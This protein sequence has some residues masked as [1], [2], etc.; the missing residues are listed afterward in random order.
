[1]QAVAKLRDDLVNYFGAL[2]TRE[3]RVETLILERQTIV[4]DPQLVQHRGM[5]I[6]NADGVGDDVVAV[7]IGF[8]E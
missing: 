5:Q 1:M 7:V 8:S 4:I 6:E 2:D 3:P